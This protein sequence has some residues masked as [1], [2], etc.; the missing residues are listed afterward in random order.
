MDEEH[1]IIVSAILFCMLT[2]VTCSGVCNSMRHKHTDVGH[3]E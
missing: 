3:A 2:V 1:F